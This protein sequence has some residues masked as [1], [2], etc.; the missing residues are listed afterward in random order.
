MYGYLTLSDGTG[1]AHSEMKPDGS[2][3]V[4][5]EKPVEGG[6]QHATCYLPDYRWEKIE[7]FSGEDQ[8]RLDKILHD[9]AHLILE[10]SQEGGFTNAAGYYD[11]PLCDLLWDG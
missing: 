2:V 9:N 11:R 5:F 6:F 8:K 3:K 4:Y 1:I 10:F 7:G